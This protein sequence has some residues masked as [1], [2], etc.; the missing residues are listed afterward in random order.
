MR[1][2]EMLSR[3]VEANGADQHYACCFPFL[4]YAVE[5]RL[6]THG[7]CRTE[8]WRLADGRVSFGL[9]AAGGKSCA[10]LGAS[11]ALRPT[12]EYA[13]MTLVGEEAP[14]VWRFNESD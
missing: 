11:L 6:S 7:L 3:L 2:D 4:G 5:D 13:R 14:Y 1:Y 9:T 8:M 10:L 12:P